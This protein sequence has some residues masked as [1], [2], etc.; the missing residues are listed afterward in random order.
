MGTFFKHIFDLITTSPGNLIFHVVVAFSIAGALQAA[1]GLW[2]DQEFPQG[3]RMVIGL[4]LLLGLRFGAFLLAGFVNLGLFNSDVLL[5]I[6][7]R[8][9]TA[10]S[11]V[12]IIWLWAFP[13]PARKAD[14]ATVLLGLLIFVLFILNWAWRGTQTDNSAYNSTLASSGWEI[15][16]LILLTIGNRLV[17]IRRPNGWGYG[18]AM[19]GIAI[20]GHLLHLL[21]PD[22]TSDFAG[23]VR[24][25]D[26]TSFPM[27]WALPNRFNLPVEVSPKSKPTKTITPKEYRPY[28]IEPT[29]F[30]SI[31]SLLEPDSQTGIY[32][33]ISKTIAETLLADICVIL[34]P[35]SEIDTVGIRS[36]YDLIRETKIDSVIIGTEK[37]PMLVSAM[38]RSRPLRLPASST[39]L[40]LFSIGEVLGLGRTGHLLV[41][42]VPDQDGDTPLLGLALLSPYSDRRWNREDQAYLNSIATNL[43]PILQQNNNQVEITTDLKSTREKLTNLKSL[44]DETRTENEGLRAEISSISQQVVQERE[45]EITQLVEAHQKS[46]E[47]IER[48]QIENKRL[49]NLIEDLVADSKTVTSNQAQAKEELKLALQEIGRLKNQLSET[50]Q[51]LIAAQQVEPSSDNLSEEQIEV[52]MSIAQELRQPMSSIMGYTDLLLGESVGILGALQR[53]FLD[54]I[55]VSTERMDTL[56]DDLFQ[57]VTLDTGGL[58][59]RP[60]AVDLGR[61]IDKAIADTRSQLQERGI[62]IRLD[63]PEKMPYLLADYDALQQVLIQLLKNAGTVTPVDGEIFLRSSIY[64]TDDDQDYV[65]MQVS[66]QGGGIPKED[67]PRVFSRLYRADNPLIQGIGDTG[68]GLSIVKALVEAH[69]GRIWVDTEMG[70][71]STFSLLIPL[72]TDTF[73]A[74]A[75]SP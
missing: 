32:Q 46:K 55:K 42:F 25:F 39:S 74:E 24:L 27:L 72:S 49:E 41:A 14:A 40:D 75:I 63:F 65:L 67:L 73:P 22:I 17:V 58:E 48:L 60:E 66:D 9:I 1:V 8:A 52:F 33:K 56:L 50:D 31:L 4:G 70:K 29:I 11:L 26:M 43:A 16:T 59:L 3:R 45:K 57:I 64:P 7:D 19:M 62:V 69:S 5:P 23:V 18:L 6:L 71:G 47:I 10:S 44:L 68:V 30:N 54:R 28:A 34:M 37:I 13:E 36:G 15:F 53:K 21:F 38:Q 2:R 51:Q 35:P 12:L 20:L 61:A